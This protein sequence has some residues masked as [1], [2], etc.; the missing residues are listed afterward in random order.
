M[1]SFRQQAHKL[2]TDLARHFPY[3]VQVDP[4]SLAKGMRPLPFRRPPLPECGALFA[5]AAR[6]KQTT[7]FL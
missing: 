2:Q 7:I 1:R 6:V 4:L 5:N 3:I